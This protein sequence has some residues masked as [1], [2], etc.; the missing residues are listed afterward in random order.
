LADLPFIVRTLARRG[1]VKPGRPDRMLG[2]LQSLR[3]WGY[4]LAGEL[5]ASAARWPDRTAVIDD[6]RT[7]TYRRLVRRT[8]RVARAL[9]ESA[10]VQA[11][12]RVGLLCRNHGGMVELMIAV[13]ALGADP[14]LMNTGLAGPQLAAVAQQQH[15]KLLCH[16]AEFDG[17]VS[18]IPLSVRLLPLS[19]VDGLVAQVSLDPL[20]PPE[21]EG[22]IIVLTSG[23]TGI[24]KGA[25]RPV[26]PGFGPLA[27]IIA[28]IP[29]Q[30]GERMHICAPLF[31]TW[32][33]SALQLVFGLSGTAILQRRFDPYDTLDAIVR[34]KATALFVVPVMIQRLLEIDPV[35]TSLRVVAASGSA[36]SGGLATRFM[37]AYGDI[38]YNLY[39][40][41]E[42]SWASIAT[43]DELRFAPGTAGRPPHGTQVAVLDG[44]GDPV[45]VGHV[46]R[47]FV[48][49]EMLFDGYTSGGTKEM[50]NGLLNTGDLGHVNRSG[51]LFIDGR[52]DDM[53]VSG[54]ENVFPLEVEDL[55]GRLPQV[56]EVAVAGVP[57]QEFGQRLAAYIVLMPGAW[58]DAGAV[59]AYVRE[60]L[61]RFCVP[62]DVVFMHALPR[63]AT[64]KVVP[65]ELPRL[66]G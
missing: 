30:A 12:D 23:T 2:Q 58:L 18:D 40:S 66:T 51:L 32:G 24:P 48:G 20:P 35:A 62:R 19:M 63:N 6:R 14:V 59:R 5:R 27:S 56:R 53:I 43:P 28:R 17:A 1:L 54:G 26:P 4:T 7:I 42:A 3:T 22:R 34:T 41:T 61:A 16:D 44:N 15:L 36:L 11:G 65:R 49:N 47:I 9:Q 21:R 60:H 25:Q 29:I 8:D 57:D 45:P 39:G 37:N 46:G 33:L 64:G 13:T 50:R 52:E 31:H 10:G 38:L 55:L